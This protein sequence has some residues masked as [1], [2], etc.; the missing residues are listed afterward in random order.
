MREAG[1]MKYLRL[2]F[3]LLFCFC[4]V[5]SGADG[6]GPAVETPRNSEQSIQLPPERI[7]VSTGETRRF[8][9]PFV[10]EHY[11]SSTSNARVSLVDGRAFEVEGVSA[12]SAVITVQAEGISKEFRV[13]VSSSLMP[14]YRELSRELGD[15]PEVSVELSDDVLTLRGEITRTSRWDYFRRV[16]RRYE[17]RCRNYVIFRPGP[18]LFE[19]LKKQFASAGYPVVETVSPQNPGQLRFQTRP[20]PSVPLKIRSAPGAVLMA[21]HHPWRHKKSYRRNQNE[22]YEEMARP[23]PGVRIHPRSGRML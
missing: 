20:D 10:I 1:R 11:R 9:V 12:G 23:A 21:G 18:E 7:S 17:D 5:S 14:I 6:V 3:F 2:F 19:E 4:L 15:L 8:E 16:V 13:T 22:T